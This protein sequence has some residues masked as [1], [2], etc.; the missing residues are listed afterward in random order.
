MKHLK[1]LALTILILLITSTAFSARL[2]YPRFH[3]FDSNGDPVSGGLVNTYEPGTTTRK[4]SFS[5]KSLTI[6]NTNP[7][8]LDS[9]GEAD[10]YLSGSYKIV[11]TDS[12]EVVLWTLDNVQGTELT[13]TPT[14]VDPTYNFITHSRFG[15]WSNSG[16]PFKITGISVYISSSGT[17]LSMTS[18]PTASGVSMGY[19]LTYDGASPSTNKDTGN[20][21]FEITA[22]LGND[23]TIT[24]AFSG[25]TSPESG[26]TTLYLA[27]PGTIT[28]GTT[29]PDGWFKATGVD[30]YRETRSENTY[31]G[32]YYALLIDPVSATGDMTY[33]PGGISGNSEFIVQ[34]EDL[35]LN[36][37]AWVKTTNAGAQLYISVDG[38]ETL[39]TAHTGTGTYECL[40]S[41]TT[42]NNIT[43]HFRTGVTVT[44]SSTDRIWVSQPMLTFGGNTGCNYAIRPGEIVWLEKQV[45][46]A[47]KDSPL[48]ADDVVLNVEILSNL[49]LPKD[50]AALYGAV[51]VENSSITSAHGITFYNN[52]SFDTGYLTIL[53][54]VNNIKANSSGWIGT[55]RN[56]DIFQRIT[57][58][59]D[60]LSAYEIH[61]SGINLR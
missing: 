21:V 34:F 9:D 55:D 54:A 53:P 29:G 43:R 30:L 17:S 14:T 25:V 7:V 59:D 56:G 60:T 12:S 49:V 32:S 38:T 61:I 47:P 44:T 45:D 36:W 51:T 26:Q 39:S 6:E 57:E 1:T 31:P 15:V 5:D 20:T 42:P 24:P 23:I 10:I 35:E 50:I 48:A 28:S 8:V 2:L 16:G 22:I 11:L 40:E 13:T 33:W 46:I 37:S 27:M 52:S 4:A 19:H 3:A 58:A 41:T 18:T